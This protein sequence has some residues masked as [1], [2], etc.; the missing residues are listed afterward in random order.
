M[1]FEK[2]L[3]GEGASTGHYLHIGRVESI[4]MGPY[5]AGN[6]ETPDPEYNSPADIGKIRYELLY[7]TFNSAYSS[8]IF[9]PAYPIFN[10][11]KQYP[12]VNEI[13]LIIVGPSEGLND[14]INNQS[15]FYF[16]PF[17]LWN[18]PNHGA[19]PNLEAYRQYLSQFSQEPRYSG[20]A[21]L[22][23]D[24][25]FG[26]T[27]QENQD[28]TNL[29]PFEGDT[30]IQSRFGQSVRFGST[31]SELKNSNN[32][33]V[34]GSNGDPITIITN[35]VARSGATAASKFDTTVEDINKD[36]SSIYLTSTQNI[37]LEDI[38]NFPLKSFGININV[39]SQPILQIPKKPVSREVT[40]ARTQDQNS[41]K[42]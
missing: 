21:I 26:Y 28:V 22:G 7:S 5:I 32:W 17:N 8:K 35:K 16:P 4:V 20:Q 19:F 40:S 23:P 33:S 38:N 29:Q 24:L 30:I 1:S 39:V 2:L 15:Y 9:R 25:P 41:A 34:T 27:F 13:V 3:R 10:F 31:V 37:F 12:V 36:G 42:S 18:H 14:N 11:I 6:I